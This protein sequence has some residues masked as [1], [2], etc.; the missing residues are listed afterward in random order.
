ML[1]RDEKGILHVVALSGGKDSTALALRLAETEP[2]PYNYVCTPTGDELPE[3]FAHWRRIGEI[4][5]R[6]ILPIMA[7]TGLSGLV[8][9]EKMIPNHSA[10]FC[11]R[12]LK[13][14]PYQAWLREQV[15]HGP[16]FSYVGLRADEP[17]RAGGAYDIAEVAVRFPMREWG[18]GVADVLSY[19]EQRDVSIPER[20]DCARCYEQQL[21]EWWLLWKQHPEIY[22]DAEQQ[23]AEMSELVGKLVSWRS[24]SRDAWPAQLKDLRVEFERGRIPRDTSRVQRQRDLFRGGQCRVCSM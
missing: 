15:Q 14:E 21:I 6:R 2:H 19:L 4:L 11:T 10:R 3:M 5:G 7:H 1:E 24:P 13:I 23:E 20:T 18:W 9:E 22:A 17:G 8:R 12:K 16:V